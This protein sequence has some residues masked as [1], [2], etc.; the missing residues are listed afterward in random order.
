[1]LKWKCHKEKLWKLCETAIEIVNEN[2]NRVTN[3]ES[4]KKK[5]YFFIIWLTSWFSW[6]NQSSVSY[7]AEKFSSFEACS[8]C[9]NQNKKLVIWLLVVTQFLK[10]HMSFFRPRYLLGPNSSLS[11]PKN[12]SK[13]RVYLGPTLVWL[14]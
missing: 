9:K 5:I 10:R 6:Q 8:K 11:P 3:F 12:G 1:M 2:K 14:I 7:W 4:K 13:T